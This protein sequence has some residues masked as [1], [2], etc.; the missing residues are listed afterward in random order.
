[1]INHA[2]DKDLEFHYV[3]LT[4]APAKYDHVKEAKNI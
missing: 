4:Y 3:K 1:M 2:E